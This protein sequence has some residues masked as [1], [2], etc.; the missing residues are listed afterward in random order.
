M[1]PKKVENIVCKKTDEISSELHNDLKSHLD[2]SPYLGRNATK[3]GP[4]CQ[5]YCKTCNYYTDR[6]SKMVRHFETQKHKKHFDNPT[7]NT[8]VCEC[9]KNYKHRQS[10]YRHK[11]QCSIFPYKDEM[12]D[13]LVVVIEENK[14][15]RKMMIEHHKQIGD[16]IPQ[17]GNTINNT[18]NLQVFLNEDCKEALNMSEFI[19]S[20]DIQLQDLEHTKKHGLCD[21]I[22]NIFINGLRKIGTYKRPIHCTDSK[23]ETLYIKDDNE[24]G[25]MNR[26]EIR[27][28][29]IEI[30]DKQRKA[31]K[32]WEEAHLNWEHSEKG[33]DDW[34]SLVGTVMGSVTTNLPSENKIIKGIV[35]EVKIN[36]IK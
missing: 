36:P 29:L 5:F 20:L 4:D 8:W 34:I 18:F 16:L 26:E 13:M 19:Q 14:E 24:W 22:L 23:R 28:P 1:L 3:K 33:K 15:L 27:K 35:K 32:Q 30:A 2:D 31:I 10:F 9:G 21:G 6:S 11:K 7:L 25:R 17:I 12:K